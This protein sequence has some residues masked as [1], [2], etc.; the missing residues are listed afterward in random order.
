MPVNSMKNRPQLPLLLIFAILAASAVA[1]TPQQPPAQA[2]P[3]AQ[4]PAAAKAPAEAAPVSLTV[5][6]GGQNFRFVFFGD[7]RTT[8]VSNTTDTDPVRRKAII[9]AITKEKPA[10][11][12][13]SGDLVLS[14]GDDRDWAEWD[15]ET[16]EW[17]KASIPVFPVLGN[18][19]IHGNT[20]RQMPNFFQR[21]PKLKGNDSYTARVG[22]VEL[23][24]LDSNLPELTG[25]QSV[26][27]KATLDD[28]SPDVDFVL[29]V[30]HHP[31][32]THSH[33]GPFGGHSARPTEIAL[34]QWLEQKQK[35]LRA[36]LVVVAGHVHNYERY[37]HEGVTYIVSGGGG[38][39]PYSIP[40]T[41]TDFYREAGPSYHYCTVDVHG[42]RFILEM[43]KLEL[44]GDKTIWR[45]ADKVELTVTPRPTP[46]EGHLRPA[47]GD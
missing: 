25:P 39:T 4:A 8:P 6:P 45:V 44:V 28:L 24:T 2:A 20:S 36:R 38:A 10:F 41:P 14:G 13:V 29:I 35:S 27:L 46:P 12:S 30:L 3:E 37:E 32:Y 23:L 11:I 16:A 17:T 33:E 34:A 47:Q 31:P 22:N 26:W 15:T 9:D 43:H 21:F 7:L 1:Q 19:E 42:A 40:R 5:D 18:H